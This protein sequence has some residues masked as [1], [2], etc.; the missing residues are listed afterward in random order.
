M[1]RR[2]IPFVPLINSGNEAQQAAQQLSSLIQRNEAD[3]WRFCHL[4]DITTV[5][6]NGCLAALVGNATTVMTI[7]VAIFE[8]D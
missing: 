2:A 8:K 7:Q 1:V 5:R 6:K 3:G 4:E